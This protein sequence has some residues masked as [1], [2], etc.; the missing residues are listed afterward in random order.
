MDREE[1]LRT[2]LDDYNEVQKEM[3][4]S[5]SDKTDIE[6]I[7]AGDRVEYNEEKRKNMGMIAEDI[8]KHYTFEQLDFPK[9]YKELTKDLSRFNIS[10]VIING[11]LHVDIIMKIIKE[12]QKK[13]LPFKIIKDVQ[14]EGNIALGLVRKKKNH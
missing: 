1:N 8:I 3:L 11:N 7:V 4:S 2:N 10:K 12:V 13:Q 6:K 14:L 5:L 9:T